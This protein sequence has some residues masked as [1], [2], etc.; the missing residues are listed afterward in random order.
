MIAQNEKLWPWDWSYIEKHGTT[1][2]GYLSKWKKLRCSGMRRVSRVHVHLFQGE[3]FTGKYSP[4]D[5]TGVCSPD[6]NSMLGSHSHQ[7][8]YCA[9]KKRFSSNLGSKDGELLQEISWM[10]FLSKRTSESCLPNSFDCGDFFAFLLGKL[11]WFLMVTYYSRC[12]MYIH[13]SRSYHPNMWE[14]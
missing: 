2:N 1:E 11:K 9:E 6:N 12:I 13:P 14:G 8:A 3:D 10:G 5:S 4:E 7:P